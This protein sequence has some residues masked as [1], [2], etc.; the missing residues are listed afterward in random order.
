MA[1]DTQ[2]SGARN[3]NAGGQAHREVMDGAECGWA[4]SSGGDGG[5]WVCV[6][7]GLLVELKST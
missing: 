4:G 6:G 3:L 2:K 1:Q 5:C 7:E